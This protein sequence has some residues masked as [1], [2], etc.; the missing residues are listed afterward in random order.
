[1][2]GSTFI[3]PC[4]HLEVG[5]VEAIDTDHAGLGLEVTVVRVGGVQVIFKHSQTVQ[6]FN[7]TVQKTQTNLHSLS[8]NKRICQMNEL[9]CP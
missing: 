8:L 4:H 6:V 1:M 2:Q 7:L 5:A 3:H 9:K